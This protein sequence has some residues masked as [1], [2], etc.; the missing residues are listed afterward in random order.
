MEMDTDIK[1]YP[2]GSLDL[3]LKIAAYSQ[4][5]D[6]LYFKPV[7]FMMGHDEFH[8]S[9]S[10][11]GNWT[12]D[13]YYSIGKQRENIHLKKKNSHNDFH[14][15]EHHDY[16]DSVKK[17]L[18]PL[19]I[20]IIISLFINFFC[21]KEFSENA[22]YNIN[23]QLL[24]LMTLVAL[25]LSLVEDLPKTHY[26]KFT[27]LLFLSSFMICAFNF[28]GSMVMQ[29]LCQNNILSDVEKI[30]KRFAIFSIF[31]ALSL[32]LGCFLLTF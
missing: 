12:I 7:N 13:K 19:S 17:I 8:R 27:D 15:S 31:L 5:I 24:L 4:T 32:I 3:V 11:K 16:T 9:N 20:F 29:Y 14:F 1:Q 21:R 2:L 25:K 18:A 30:E 28:L 22:D 6:E 23:G 26:L 10:L